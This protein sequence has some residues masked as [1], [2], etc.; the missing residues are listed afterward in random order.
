MKPLNEKI[1]AILFDLDGTILDIDLDRFILEYIKLLA[2]N[3]EHLIKPR[4][5]IPNLMEA[6]KAVEKNDGI[7]TNE[8]VYAEV[9]FPSIGFKREEIEPYFTKFYEED[10]S[11]LS[12]WAK[13]MPNYSET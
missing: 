8:E 7:R 2:K 11:Q 9:F 12:Q 10:F 3:V 5:F 1:K 4:K 6:S 13:K